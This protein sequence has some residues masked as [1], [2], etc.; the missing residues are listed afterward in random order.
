MSLPF[1]SRHN[2]FF[3]LQQWSPDN[4]FTSLSASAYNVYMSALWLTL[5]TQNKFVLIDTKRP[6]AKP[7][8]C[9]R[10]YSSPA[11][12]SRNARK[13]YTV[14]FKIAGCWFTSIWAIIEL[15]GSQRPY[16]LGF[17][18]LL[19]YQYQQLSNFANKSGYSVNVFRGLSRQRVLSLRWI[20]L[21]D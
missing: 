3:H 12:L 14:F 4:E 18:Y 16:L 15:N 1:E 21:F 2:L 7:T 17:M 13:Q 11:N 9:Q 10:K 8:I 5:R 19:L 6:S 20:S